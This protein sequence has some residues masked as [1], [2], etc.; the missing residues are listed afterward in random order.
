MAVP[1]E[2]Y[3][4]AT[5]IAESWAAIGTWGCGGKGGGVSPQRVTKKMAGK[6]SAELILNFRSW[7]ARAVADRLT[8]DPKTQ[9]Y[10]IIFGTCRLGT[11]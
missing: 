11:D 8:S 7:A 10:D 3:V 1:R 6:E 9:Y 4:S 2:S 5:A